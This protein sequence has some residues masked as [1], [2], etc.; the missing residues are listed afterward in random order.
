MLLCCLKG[1]VKAFW[2]QIS[3][4]PIF[5][6]PREE[7]RPTSPYS[8]GTWH[9]I[10]TDAKINCEIIRAPL[11]KKR[12]YKPKS[13][14]FSS[15]KEDKSQDNHFS[16]SDSA[17]R[18]L[19]KQ[20]K[21][22]FPPLQAYSHSSSLGIFEHKSAAILLLMNIHRRTDYKPPPSIAMDLPKLLL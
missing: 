2:K 8:L 12:P 15:V 17:G 7:Q 20:N 18:E 19:P 22:C 11:S 5:I 14:W 6:L 13:L 4:I 21:E 3:N 16:N 1:L 9:R 10:R